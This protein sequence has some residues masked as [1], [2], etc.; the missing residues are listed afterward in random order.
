MPKSEIPRAFTLVE[1]LIVIAIIAVLAS[2]LLPAVGR[3]QQNAQR[4]KSASNLK[5]LGGALLGYAADNE[6]NIPKL[7]SQTPNQPANSRWTWDLMPYL[8]AERPDNYDF[9]N[10]PNLP[11]AC[12]ADKTTRSPSYPRSVWLSYAMNLG[13]SS[14]SQANSARLTWIPAS[15]AA[16]GASYRKLSAIDKPSQVIMMAE[17]DVGV[18]GIYPGAQPYIQQPGGYCPIAKFWDKAS[19]PYSEVR[20]NY[21][22]YDGHTEFLKLKDTIGNGTVTAPGGYWTIDPN[23]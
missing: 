5:T 19:T 22:F 10:W 21:V 6:Q 13:I 4:T 18:L 17:Q 15:D 20:A 12:P 14:G 7:L 1:L 16:V 11:F 2:L 3:M 8:G 9:A 23:D